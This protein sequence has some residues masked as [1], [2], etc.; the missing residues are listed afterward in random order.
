MFGWGRKPLIWP[1]SF[2]VLAGRVANPIV[3]NFT[4]YVEYISFALDMRWPDVVHLHLR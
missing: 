3:S 4:Q 2:S 1:V